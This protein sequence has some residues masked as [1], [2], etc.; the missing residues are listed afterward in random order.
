MKPYDPSQT[1]IRLSIHPALLQRY[2]ALVR[3]PEFNFIDV[4]DALRSALLSFAAFKEH[5]LRRIRGE[6]WS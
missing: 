5:E 6:G 3:A 4:N 1:E 2:E